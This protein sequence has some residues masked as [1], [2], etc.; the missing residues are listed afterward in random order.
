AGPRIGHPG[1][2]QHLGGDLAPGAVEHRQDLD[3]PDLHSASLSRSRNRRILPDPV[4]GISSISISWVGTL[5]CDSRR[6]QSLSTAAASSG[7]VL[8]TTNATGTSPRLSCGTPTTAASSTS[9]EASSASS[10]SAG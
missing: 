9:A 7:A 1:A 10:T 4:R 3:V 8:G 6:P 2:T 5:N